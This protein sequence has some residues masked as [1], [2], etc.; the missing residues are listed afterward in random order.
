M[1]FKVKS[2]KGDIP[3]LK[4]KYQCGYYEMHSLEEATK[5]FAKNDS[6]PDVKLNSQ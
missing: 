1:F 6:R 4:R 3:E 5:P 2:Q